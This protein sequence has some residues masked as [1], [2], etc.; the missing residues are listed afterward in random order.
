MPADHLLTT[1][2]SINLADAVDALSAAA[3]TTD[4]PIGYRL[5]Q[6][7]VDARQLRQDVNDLVIDIQSN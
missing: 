4:G 2:E 6:L 3:E 5:Q 7:A 1:I